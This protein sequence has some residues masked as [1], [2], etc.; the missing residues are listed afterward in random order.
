MDQPEL[1]K[2]GSVY[3]P[4]LGSGTFSCVDK[5]LAR[6]QMRQVLASIVSEFTFELAPKERGREEFLAD[7]TD[8]F[9]CFTYTL[10]LVFHSRS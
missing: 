1:I 4:F 5:A 6:F 9:A 10:N 3:V 2:D 7:A 8:C